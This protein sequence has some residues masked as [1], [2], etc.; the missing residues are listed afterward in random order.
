VW[1]RE[2]YAAADDWAALVAAGAILFNAARVLRPPLH[3]LMDREQ[4]EIAER[5]RR[6]STDVSGAAGV[7]KTFA[8]TSGLRHLVDMHIE[9]EREMPV[10]Q[11]HDVGH[12][13]K[14][15]IGRAMPT[16]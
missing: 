6:V 9:V 3:E 13:V 2:R 4:P 16:V 8:R 14:E 1:G 15:V 5:V 11:A 10:W 7:E 12:D